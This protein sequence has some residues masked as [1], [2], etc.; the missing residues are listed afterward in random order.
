MIN[1]CG[2]QMRTVIHTMINQEI[3]EITHSCYAF[4]KQS[5]LT[6]SNSKNY[7]SFD[8]SGSS[9]IPQVPGTVGI[10]PPKPQGNN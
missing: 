3:L 7:F 8:C 5:F 4:K 2:D 6:Y 10:L 1:W 9:N